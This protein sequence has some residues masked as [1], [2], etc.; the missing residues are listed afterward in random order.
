MGGWSST[1]TQNTKIHPKCVRKAS[2]LIIDILDKYQKYC[3]KKG[4]LSLNFYGPVGSAYYYKKD[5]DENPNAMYGDIDLLILYPGSPEIGQ[6]NKEV[7]RNNEHFLEFIR[8]EK[9]SKINVEETLRSSPSS[10]KLITN[11]NKPMQLDF[12]AT[13]KDYAQWTYSRYIPV[14][15]IKGFIIGKLY[16]TLGRQLYFTAGPFG[17]RMKW[18]EGKPIPSRF[19]K[20]VTIDLITTDYQYFLRDVTHYLIKKTQNKKLQFSTRFKGFDPTKDRI[21]DLIEEVAIMC[22]CLDEAG[23]LGSVYDT[24][25]TTLKH[26]IK[27]EYCNALDLT[28]ASPKFDKAETEL[29]FHNYEIA[30]R[31]IELGKKIAELLNE[32]TESKHKIQEN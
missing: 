19:R 20:D 9:P 1:T 27:E 31:N 2:L 4:I 11:G 21:E 26:T 17:S 16:A 18:K 22:D 7:K 10:I 5:L 12:V 29:A 15:G 25:S 28:A 32:H 13:F 23:V 6:E 3:A 8:S 30:K 24:D 14:R